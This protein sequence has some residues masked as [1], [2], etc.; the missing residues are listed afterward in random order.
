MA[1]GRDAPI[2]FHFRAGGMLVTPD[3]VIEKVTRILDGVEA[4]YV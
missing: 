1:L 4:H 2:Y 3:D